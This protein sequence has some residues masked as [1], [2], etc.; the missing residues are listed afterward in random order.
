M[1]AV[2]RQWS[3]SP[4]SNDLSFFSKGLE[5]LGHFSPLCSSKQSGSPKKPRCFF[6]CGF[7]GFFLVLLGWLAMEENWV[8]LMMSKLSLLDFELC[9]TKKGF[10]SG[11][12]LMLSWRFYPWYII[13]REPT[14]GAWATIAAQSAA[15]QGCGGQD[16]QGKVV[17]LWF[18]GWSFSFHSRKL[19]WHLKM[20]PWKRRFLLTTPS[21]WGS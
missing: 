20:K 17:G 2:W 14:G 15:H 10:R 9:Y 3:P 19:T 1:P 16:R 18:G 11:Q 4:S 7:V 13:P 21:F 5:M 12:F 6:C 8:V